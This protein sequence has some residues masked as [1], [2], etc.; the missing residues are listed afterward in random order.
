MKKP[1]HNNSKTDK[2][3]TGWIL[4][5]L[6]P[7]LSFVIIWLLVPTERNF[8]GFIEYA[9]KANVLSKF[10]SLAVLPNLLVFFIF[11]WTKMDRA[12]KG[13]LYVTFV[14]ALAVVAV[15]FLL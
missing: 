2:P 5:L 13:V 15:K 12:A 4:G 3:L 10:L 14:V 8:A 6:V 11:I 7:P 1:E 9:M